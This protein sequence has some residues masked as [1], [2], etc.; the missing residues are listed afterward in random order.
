VTNQ[1]YREW[2]LFCHFSQPRQRLEIWLNTLYRGKL[3][4][5][6][7]EIWKLG[8]WRMA[9]DCSLFH[10]PLSIS[11]YYLT[12]VATSGSLFTMLALFGFGRRFSRLTQIIGSSGGRSQV[13]GSKSSFNLPHATCHLPQELSFAEIRA[14]SLP[15]IYWWQLELFKGDD[16][17]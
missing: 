9:I 16:C 3:V 7:L 6:W 8:D 15:D 11:S 2:S 17:V 1:N 14:N 10:Y 5:F 4:Q 13:A 12:Q